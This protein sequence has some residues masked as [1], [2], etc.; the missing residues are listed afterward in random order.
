MLFSDCMS[1]S[2]FSL[3]FG[4]FEPF[5]VQNVSEVHWNWQFFDGLCSISLLSCT[6]EIM[7]WLLSDYLLLLNS[8]FPTFILSISRSSCDN[9]K[10]AAQREMT[11]KA[12]TQDWWHFIEEKYG[13]V[14]EIKSNQCFS[15]FDQGFELS[16]AKILLKTKKIL[17][18]QQRSKTKKKLSFLA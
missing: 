11:A 7:W 18:K 5:L 17:I 1:A 16:L 13:F 10:L 6:V 4:S 12:N 2:S 8:L 3:I 14:Q 9:C 15:N